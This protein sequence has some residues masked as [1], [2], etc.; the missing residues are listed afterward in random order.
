MYT[1]LLSILAAGL[2]VLPAAAQDKT[3][4]KLEGTWKVTSTTKNGKADEEIQGDSLTFKGN[5]AT[6]KSKKREEKATFKV[7][8]S[9]APRQIDITPEGEKVTVAGSYKIEGDTLTLCFPKDPTGTRPTEFS[10]KE[11]SNLMLIVLKREKK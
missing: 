2:L 3:K 5:M 4:E 8:D 7:D 9:K 10:S 6:V 1:R 11:G